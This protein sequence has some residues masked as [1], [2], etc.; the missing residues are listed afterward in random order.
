[1]KS[2]LALSNTRKV[3]MK[4]NKILSTLLLLPTV[5]CTWAQFDSGS[6]GTVA[7]VVAPG[8]TLTTNLPPDGV[9]HFTT[10]SIGNNATL[11]FRT[12]ALNT[13]VY[14][15]AKGDVVINGTIDVSG[16]GTGTN[17][18][19]GGEPGPGGFGGGAPG[20]L[21]QAGPPP[22]ALGGAGH[23]PGGG[24]DISSQRDGFYAAPSTGS[25]YGYPHL[26]PLVGGSGG[27]GR[28]NSITNGGGGGGGAILIASSTRIQI[29]TG[30]KVLAQGGPRSDGNAGFGSGGA[31]RLV[32]P[33]VLGTGSL[34][35][36]GDPSAAALASVRG[37][38][39]IDSVLRYDPLDPVNPA[40]RFSLTG[41]NSIHLDARVW[42]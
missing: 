37:R 39:R 5:H 24:R 38:I 25:G 32:A 29:N 27:C 4:W 22:S 10:I 16:R 18:F 30:G 2:T 1:M 42:S 6:T 23:G 11:R 8:T 17:A 12:N 19:V 7:L 20:F 13:P 35:V 34:D 3:L 36:S 31:I 28:G 33:M 26:I 41:S 40:N 15:L 21:V 14:L 9:L